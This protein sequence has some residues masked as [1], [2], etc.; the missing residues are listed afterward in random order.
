MIPVPI[1]AVN[2]LEA[3][4]RSSVSNRSPKNENA[5][6]TLPDIIPPHT[7]RATYNWVY[8]WAA[9]VQIAATPPRSMVPAYNNFLEGTKS[10]RKPMSADTGRLSTPVAKAMLAP[11]YRSRCPGLKRKNSAI[12]VRLGAMRFCGLHTKRNARARRRDWA[13]RDW[14]HPPCCCASAP[15]SPLPLSL[16]GAEESDAVPPRSVPLKAPP[17]ASSSSVSE[18]E[19]ESWARSTFSRGGMAGMLPRP[20]PFFTLSVDLR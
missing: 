19:H 11:R 16:D 5:T 14:D 13:W 9:P 6:G 18:A 20:L 8:V 7:N 4:F 12:W 3:A 2:P 1:M 15:E 10:A 17:E